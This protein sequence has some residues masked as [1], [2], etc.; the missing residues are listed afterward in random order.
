MTFFIDAQSQFS[1]LGSNIHGKTVRLRTNDGANFTSEGK[2]KLSSY[3]E[4][5]LE[6][7]FNTYPY[8]HKNRYISNDIKQFQ[9][10]LNHIEQQPPMSLYEM[11]QKNTR[12]PDKTNPNSIKKSWSDSNGHQIDRADNFYFP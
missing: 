7:I 10:K 4:K 1:F 5:K 9:K 3:L 12:L 6:M 8:I 11:A 2:K